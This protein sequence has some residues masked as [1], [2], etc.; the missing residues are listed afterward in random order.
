MMMSH[1]NMQQGPGYSY[2]TQS[3][4]HYKTDESSVKKR[5]LSP[6]YLPLHK[7]IVMHGVS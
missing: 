6:K 4:T 7:E 3:H 2:M 1:P 5:R